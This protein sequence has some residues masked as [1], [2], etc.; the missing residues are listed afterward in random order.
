M[1]HH[2]PDIYTQI[3]KRVKEGRWEP[4]G[5]FWVEPDL[6]VP[7]GE[8]LVRQAGMATGSSGK[9]SAYL[10][11]GLDAR[12]IRLL[13]CATADSQESA[14]DFFVT[15]KLHWNEYSRFPTACSN[16]KGG[17]ISYRR[18]K[19]VGIQR[20]Y[21]TSSLLEQW[22]QYTQKDRTMSL[23]FHSDLAMAAAARPRDVGRGQAF[24]NMPGLRCVRSARSAI[25]SIV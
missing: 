19:A 7:S 14:S 15:S 25:R 3:R 23:S 22:N 9:N 16:G 10:T 18:S 5:C 12:Y 17:W 24:E 4:N 1:K 11:S 20:E 13:L 2:Y 6:N 8:S 21:R